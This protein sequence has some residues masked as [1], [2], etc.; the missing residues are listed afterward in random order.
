MEVEALLNT[1]RKVLAEAKVN[2]FG[3]T[4][5]DVDF[6]AFVN[7]APDTLAWMSTDPQRNTVGHVRGKALI[8]TQP[9]T[10]QHAKPINTWQNTG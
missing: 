5:G 8:N 3:D 2:T 4:L 1:L 9:V 6:A 7:T 10:L